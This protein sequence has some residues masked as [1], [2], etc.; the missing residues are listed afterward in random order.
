MLLQEQKEK[1]EHPRMAFNRLVLVQDESGLRTPL[2]G[3]NYST[4]GM[5]INSHKPLNFG[6]FVEL[7][8][9]LIEP[10]KREINITAEVLDNYREGDLFTT[11]VKFVGELKLN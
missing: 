2:V 5:A 6:D 8:F 7:N 9:W 1:R 10:K 11:S 3:V 4:G